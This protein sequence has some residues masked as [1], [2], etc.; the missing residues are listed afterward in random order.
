MKIFIVL[1]AYNEGK[2]IS[3]VLLELKKYYKNII[4]VDDGSKDNT[5]E[6]ARKYNVTVLKHVINRGQGAALKTGI[7]FAIQNNADIIVTFDADGQF[8][9]NE[10]K[11]LIEPIE[12]KA[13]DIV[14]GSRF[15]GKTINMPFLKKVVLKFGILVVYLLYGIKVSDSQCGF[16]AM[17]RNAAE[18]IRITCNGM[19]HAGEIL[20]EI[21]R[22]KLI[23]NEVPITVIYDEYSLRKGQSWTRSITLG[24]RMLFRRFLS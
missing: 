14:L 9:V 6:I 19:E 22:Q 18:K 12:K 20:W 7:D 24:L 1:A 15:L 17:S 16:R 2:K 21:M 23:Y 3:S 13:A 10:I 11:L 5:Y 4:V 8:L